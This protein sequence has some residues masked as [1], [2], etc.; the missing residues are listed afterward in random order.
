MSFT[1]PSALF[2]LL[3]LP[4]FI[5]IGFPRLAYRRRRDSIALGLR[6]LLVILLILSLAG[7]QA[8]RQADKLAVVFLIDYSDS[9][10]SAAKSAAAIYVREALQTM[11]DGDQAAVVIFGANALVEHP[12]DDE[13]D[14]SQIGSQPITLNTDLA[15]AIRLGLALFPA[16]TAKRMVIL[17]DGQQTT[18]DAE[19]AAE[20][21][22]AT[23]VQIDYVTYSRQRM[24]EVLVSAVQAPSI[25]NEGERFD[26]IVTL[27]SEETTRANLFIDAAGVPLPNYPVTV[28]LEAGINRFVV[29]VSGY[30][31]GFVDFA[32]EITP[33]GADSFQKNNRLTAFTRIEGQPRILVVRPDPAQ[34]NGIDETQ[35]L[36]PALTE[37]GLQI[38]VL[39]PSELPLGLP[40]LSIYESIILANVSA[41]DLS[42]T[43][44]ELLQSYVRD[45][46]GGLVA[47]GGDQS[48]GVGGYFQTPLE[49]MLPVEMRIRDQERVP[50]LTMVFVID[51]SGSMEIASLSGVSNLEL[52]KEAVMR[53]FDFLNDRDKAGVVTFEQFS[54]W[55]FDIQELG[56]S[57]NRSRLSDLVASLRPGGGT[58]IFGG[59][60]AASNVL[61]SDSSPLKHIILLT[62]GGASPEGIVPLVGRM[63]DNHDITTSVVAVGED[64]A[65][66]L[67]DVAR[68]GN[69]NFHVTLD[70]TTIPSIFAAET[71]LATRSYIFEDPFFPVQTARSPILE[72]ITS[73]PELQGYVAT[74]PKDTATVILTGPNEDPILASWQY[75]LG[76]SV[77]FTSDATGRW[78]AD[79]T[80][81]SGYPDFWKQVVNWTI[82]QGRDSNVE[83][84]VEE[85]GESAAVIVDARD[86]NGRY[87]NA[88]DLDVGIVFP[89]EEGSSLEAGGD[90]PERYETQLR[91]VAPGRYEAIFEPPRV[92]TYFIR[93][94]GVTREDAPVQASVAETTG[95][96]LSYSSEYRPR[97]ANEDFLTGLARTTGGGDLSNN[98]EAAFVHNLNQEEA[99][100]PLYPYL[101][102]LAAFLLI[103][104]IAVRR[105]VINKS[106]I[107]R[108]REVFSLRRR[109]PVYESTETAERM[110]GLKEVKRRTVT[111]F[112]SSAE[113]LPPAAS[114][115]APLG[116]APPPRRTGAAG[117]TPEKQERPVRATPVQPASSAPDESTLASR[118][119]KKKRGDD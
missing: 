31:T 102:T 106:D 87:L 9:M 111:T 85:R 22:E 40:Q 11:R 82:T 13:V 93:V 58:D 92:G 91:Q 116:T 29:P 47:I 108:L 12:M 62:D 61:P 86:N 30:T 50:P 114:S 27:E 95:W 64:Y 65:P 74:T 43:R 60:T 83:V 70:I 1:N 42:P 78:G 2:L 98:S 3:L 77:A 103:L 94:A 10:D 21:A 63:F 38:D 52:A 79:W 41:T 53:S 49:E 45:L 19:R 88:L 109:A 5:W 68:R 101:L 99:A 16:D 23:G 67:Q 36:I 76:R 28:D 66:W 8:R 55:V 104:D 14:I 118:L 73:V 35:Y 33:V 17:S 7:L 69:G 119:L 34:N 80:T 18:G 89:R 51:R 56:G 107:E 75:G 20:L 57:S 72:G 117:R 26:L 97:P 90:A 81:W 71:V 24:P 96:V 15:E 59:L 37:E 4:L 112:E 32:V 39:E 110:S 105:L 25:V 100:L 48:Y 46:G 113:V 54:S 115:P 84:W 6:L 44:M